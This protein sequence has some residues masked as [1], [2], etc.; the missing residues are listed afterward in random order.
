[1]SSSEPY[2]AQDIDAGLTSAMISDSL[3]VVGVRHNVMANHVVPLFEG[4]RALGRAST[5]RFD[6]S[7][8]DSEN[9][10]DDAIAYIDTL[11][12]GDIA[13]IATDS[14]LST[15]YWGE[16]FS[17]A[18]TGRGAVGAVT[19]GNIRDTAKIKDLKFPVWSAG[20]RPIDFR[21]RMKIV[22]MGE[23][24]RVGGVDIDHG[25]L[26]LADDDGVVVIPHALENDVLTLARARASNESMVLDELLG[27]ATLRDVWDKHRVL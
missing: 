3:D 9:P 21:A 18:A 15:A 26:I 8:E 6:I 16:L 1:M 14:N 5:V 10:Y 20:R 4:A 2:A 22:T 17:A 13:V 11:R 24:V 23:R 27:G 12:R 19:D 25:D 7:F